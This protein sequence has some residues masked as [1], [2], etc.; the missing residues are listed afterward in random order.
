MIKRG[1]NKGFTIV[2]LIVVII[3]IAIL[4]TLIALSYGNAQIQARDTQVRDAA[5]KFADAIKLMQTRSGSFPLGGTG[6]TT[7]ATSSA[8]CVDGTNG[9]QAGGFNAATGNANYKCTIGDAAIAMGYLPAAFFTSLPANAS[10][11]ALTANGVY[12]FIVT[13]CGSPAKNY[14]F[15][16]LERPAAEDTSSYNTA[17]ASGSC[18]LM[19]PAQL[20]AYGMK[21]AID[22]TKF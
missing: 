19:T 2:E 10:Y 14:L 13:S 18:A 9:W 15:Y 22:L 6:S 7:A 12:V 20:A 5:D 8:G 4:A 21:A 16:T 11:G 3:A 17:T 1:H